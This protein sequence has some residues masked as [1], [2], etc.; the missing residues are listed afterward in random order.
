M[1]EFKLY[2]NPGNLPSKP[3]PKVGSKIQLKLYGYPPYK[4]GKFS[5]RNPRHRCYDRFLK[6]REL[7]YSKMRGQKWYD[8]PIEMNLEIYA[9]KLEEKKGLDDYIGGV[10]DTLDGSHGQYFTYLPV[11]YQ[12]DC[13]VALGSHRFIES[14]E[15]YYILE[16][17]FHEYERITKTSFTYHGPISR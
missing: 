15:I 13:Q 6:L 1:K 12:D 17:V 16:I 2:P 3:E 8:G 11:V 5:I 7:A 4:D 9:P 10:M 14:S